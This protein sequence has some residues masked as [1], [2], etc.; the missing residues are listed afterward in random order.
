MCFRFVQF[1]ELAS[2]FVP[3]LN[4]LTDCRLLPVSYS[5]LRFAK[6]RE[7]SQLTCQF[8]ER[9]DELFSCECS[10]SDSCIGISCFCFYFPSV[11]LSSIHLRD[12]ERAAIRAVNVSLDQSPNNKA[13]NHIKLNVR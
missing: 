9:N 10:F 5:Y 12:A 1:K 8:Q 6:N 11:G 7:L 13:K 3:I 2:V 4:I